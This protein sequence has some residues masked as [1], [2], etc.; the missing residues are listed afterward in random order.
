MPSDADPQLIHDA[1]TLIL[2]RD[3]GTEPRVLMGQRGAGAV[4]MPNKYVFPGGRLDVS[5]RLVRPDPGLSAACRDRLTRHAPPDIADPLAAAAIR[6]LWEETGLILGRPQDVSSDAPEGWASFFATGHHPAADRMEF[7]FRAV[8][9]PGRPR[10]FDARFFMAP[11]E[12]VA[13]SLDDFSCADAELSHLHWVPMSEA[14]GLDLPFVTSI[15]L[16]ELSARLAEP[17]RPHAVPYFSHGADRSEFL[18]L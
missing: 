13:G 5:D 3:G 8:T 4:F 18:S 7:I 14:R 11:A 12:A 10:R 9:P 6:E 17:D 16:A 15:V 2:V 1:A